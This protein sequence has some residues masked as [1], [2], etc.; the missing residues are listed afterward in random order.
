[1]RLGKFNALGAAAA[2]MMLG[3][4]LGANA[5]AAMDEIRE[6]PV[7][8]RYENTPTTRR[9]AG[10]SRHAKTIANRAKRARARLSR[11]KG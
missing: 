10:P 4:G 5:V 11:K 2:A 7:T 3:A 6:P 1:M 8:L 9:G